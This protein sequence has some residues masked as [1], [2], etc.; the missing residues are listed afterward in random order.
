M[1][2]EPNAQYFPT[3]LEIYLH[4]WT[5][6]DTIAS[7][8]VALGPLLSACHS[9]VKGT[10]QLRQSYNFMP[11]TLMSIGLTSN[12]TS[13]TLNQVDLALAKYSRKVEDFPLE[14]LEQSDVI[15]I[16]CI[17]TVSLLQRHVEDLLDTA[18]SAMPL[19]A[20]KASRIDKLKLLDNRSDIEEL[21]GKL[22]DYNALSKAILNQLQRYDRAI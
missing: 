10:K 12:I 17:M 18:S 16:G 19:K 20:Q 15:K 9:I 11:L 21:F 13:S 22:K 3:I 8:H 2:L 7:M 14:L 4:T 1:Y 6:A 5:M